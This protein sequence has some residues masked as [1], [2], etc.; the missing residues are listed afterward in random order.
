MKKDAHYVM[1]HGE[2]TTG[3]SRERICSSVAIYAQ[4]YLKTWSMR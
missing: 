1:L 4:I 3:K 2:N